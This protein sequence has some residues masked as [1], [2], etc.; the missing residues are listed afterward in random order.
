[1]HECYDPNDQSI[2][3]ME[4]I[5]EQ[6]AQERNDRI[7]KLGYD[8]RWIKEPDEEIYFGMELALQ[9]RAEIGI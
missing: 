9:L 8:W 6:E 4:D 5:S 3:D 7:R 1:M 2:M